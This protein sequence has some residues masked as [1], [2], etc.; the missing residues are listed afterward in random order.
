MTPEHRRARRQGAPEP[1]RP[2]LAA[3]LNLLPLPLALGYAYLD[4]PVRFLAS[5]IARSAAAAVTWTYLAP[6]LE[7]CEGS[8]CSQGAP[9]WVLIIVPPAVLLA[10]TA[11]DGLL[12]GRAAMRRRDRLTDAER[13]ARRTGRRVLLVLGAM[14]LLALAALVRTGDAVSYSLLTAA[15]AFGW[16]MWRRGLSRAPVE[17]RPPQEPEG[18]AEE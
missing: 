7:P 17:Y 16:L 2:G 12:A 9:P 8:G 18:P 6:A 14:A 11:W 1:R 4:R 3:A 10:A 15:A 5:S 13:R